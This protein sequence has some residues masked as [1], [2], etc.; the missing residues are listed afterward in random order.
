MARTYLEKTIKLLFGG[1]RRCAFPGCDTA[2]IF[3]DRGAISVV[4]EIAH[5]RSEKRNGPRFDPTYPLEAINLPENLLLLCGVHHKPVDEHASRYPV[6]ELLRWKAR[7]ISDGTMRDL[8][9]RQVAQ[10]FQHY[11]LNALG[12]E[13][14]YKTC[15][16]LAVHVL[17]PETDVSPSMWGPGRY[18][19]TL[20]G[21]AIGYPSAEVPWDGFIVLDAL[22][23]IHT[24]QTRRALLMLRRRIEDRFS[25]W[26]QN[27]GKYKRPEY[28]IVAT[29]LSLASASDQRRRGLA[30][31]HYML[32][33]SSERFGLKG[34]AIWD[35][36]DIADLLETYAE[37]RHAVSTLTASNELLNSVLGRTTTTGT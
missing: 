14:F 15:Q 25:R 24:D 32:E 31:L 5:I 36:A 6:P 18:D 21:R 22:Y 19:A 35:E 8:S 13:G 3:E 4:A 12:P 16:A 33:V 10:I 17:G 27:D 28:V 23:F 37:V 2:L 7:Q 1:A 26:F 34:I 29:N 20:N 9:E 30:E 11:E